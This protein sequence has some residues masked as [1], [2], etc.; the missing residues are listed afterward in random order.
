M[1]QKMRRVLCLLLSVVMVLGM[2]PTTAFATITTENADGYETAVVA[3]ASNA[4]LETPTAS[5]AIVFDDVQSDEALSDETLSDDVQLDEVP[6]IETP[7]DATPNATPSDATPNVT[8]KNEIATF[9]ATRNNN[10]GNTFSTMEELAALVDALTA[11]ADLTFEYVGTGAFVIDEDIFVPGFVGL[12]FGDEDLIV[13]DGVTFGSECWV[14]CDDMIV[15]GHTD[16]LGKLEVQ[17]TLSVVGSVNSKWDIDAGDL[18]VSGEMIAK[19]WIRVYNSVD[20]SGTM[21]VYNGMNCGSALSVAKDATLSLKDCSIDIE[22]PCTLNIEGKFYYEHDRA[23]WVSRSVASVAEMETALA[24]AANETNQAIGY[25]IWIDGYKANTRTFNLTNNMVVPANTRLQWDNIDMINIMNGATVTV[26]GIL[27]VYIPLNVYGELMNNQRVEVAYQTGRDYR[28]PFDGVL[29]LFQGGQYTGGGDFYVYTDLGVNDISHIIKGL[30]MSFSK[31]V[32]T[33][34][35]LWYNGGNGGTT[36]NYNFETF[37]ELENLIN[38]GGNDEMWF[39]YNGNAPFTFESNLVLPANMYIQF[40]ENLVT[41]PAGVTVTCNGSMYGS[42]FEVA[43][44]LNLSQ[45]FDA[46]NSLVV[47]GTVTAAKSFGIGSEVE[48]YLEVT[49]TGRIELNRGAISV[50]FPGQV[51][52]LD[53]IVTNQDQSAIAFNG[54]FQDMD[55]LKD[56][57]AA[58]ENDTYRNDDRVYYDM[59]IPGDYTQ[60]MSEFTFTEDITVPA[61]ANLQLNDVTYVIDEGVT[62]TNNGTIWL[63]SPLVV[64]GTLKNNN[65]LTVSYRPQKQNE[66]GTITLGAKGMVEHDNEKEFSVI[67][68]PSVKD[69]TKVLPWFNTND[70]SVN[71]NLWD[72]GTKYW[73]VYFTSG[74]IK[75]ATPTHLTWG[76]EYRETWWNEDPVTGEITVKLEKLTKPGFMSWKTERPD[77]AR[78]QVHIYRVGENTPCASEQWGFDPQVE[79]EYRSADTFMRRDLPSGDY[80]FTVQ[81]LGDYKTYCNSDVATSGVYKFTKPATNLPA[82]SNLKWENRNDRFSN[83]TNWDGNSTSPYTDG[84]EVDLYFSKTENGTYE[85]CGGTRDRG[86]R[87]TESPLSDHFFQEMG[88]GY[89]KFK[90]RYLS[91]NMDKIG[92]GPWSDFSPVLDLKKLPQIVENSLD[93]LEQNAQQMT[94]S[95]IRTAV[96]QMDTEDLKKT[97][98]VDQENDGATKTLADLENMVGGQAPVS[99]SQAASAFNANDVS[100]V[101]ANLNNSA[102]ETDPITLVI[103]KPAKEHVIEER[104]DSSVSVSFSMTLANVA[105]PQK[106]EVPVKITLP[107]PESINPD[108]LVILHYHVDGTREWIWPY[109]YMKDGKWFADFVV[110]GFSDFVMTEEIPD[111]INGGNNGGSDNDNNDNGSSGSGSSSGGGK[112]SSGTKAKKEALPEYVISGQWTTENGKWMFTDKNGETFKNRWAAVENPYADTKKGQDAFDWFFFDANGQML[113]GWFFDGIH[114]YYLNPASDGTQGRMFTGW[115]LI[116]DKWYYLNPVSDG[117]KGAMAADT[118][119][120]GYYVNADGAWEPDKTK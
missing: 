38:A 57:I 56:L 40:H 82:V 51:I 36:Y 103:D 110:T 12:M 60:N 77:Q 24:A 2:M 18:E 35:I 16:V 111:N 44:T 90:V 79:P 15:Y 78:V 84:Y 94:A 73:R 100:V 92:N 68:E 9:T 48:S 114:W 64:N 55:E 93:Q 5:D 98:L 106:L 6:T 49:S 19:G 71:E 107:V 32:D 4:E 115:Q 47:S 37:A 20:I 46:N 113:T 42:D 25:F 105:D 33:D 7:S 89:Y 118:W 8:E 88:E 43:G 69:I 85:P 61:N 95:D 58:I 26:N 34:H 72:D 1:K 101:G 86:P 3:T 14:S 102:S 112:V 63:G 52:G 91:G 108:Y 11:P 53:R 31:N 54:R 23:I 67:A 96:Q 70:Y 87:D 99:V 22:Y 97:L 41:I 45:W 104:F 17:G 27:Q 28:P 83:W 74:L 62:L 39:Y 65:S 117:T 109:V 30:N 76:V 80:Y 10:G 116:G 75:L 66:C 13:A 120:D 50:N 81:S 119:I 59:H 29:E 21:A